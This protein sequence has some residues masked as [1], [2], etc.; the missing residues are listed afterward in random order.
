MTGQKPDVEQINLL[1]NP[2]LITE[3]EARAT[4]QGMGKSEWIRRALAKACGDLDLAAMPR[5]P[6]RSK[7]GDAA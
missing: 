5:R 1:A 2:R 3:I 6:G 7:N 4:R